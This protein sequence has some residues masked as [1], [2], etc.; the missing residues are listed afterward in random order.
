[1]AVDVKGRLA[2]LTHI[3]NAH[4]DGDT[5]VYFADANVL[6]TGDTF[7]NGRYPNI[8]FSN[9]GNING[10]IAAADIYLALAN[11]ATRIVPGHGPLGNKAQLTDY[12]AMAVASRE[13]MAELIKQGK[14]LDDILAAKPLADLDAKWA[15]NEMAAKNWMRVVYYSLKPE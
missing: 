1:M 5:Y 3:A 15:P 4:T 8:D 9:G 13:R 6:A 11:D 14:S 12:R 10:V 2:Q 7:V